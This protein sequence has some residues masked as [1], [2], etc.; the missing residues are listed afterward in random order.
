MKCRRDVLLRTGSMLSQHGSAPEIF[1]AEKFLQKKILM[2]GSTPLYNRLYLP[3]LQGLLRVSS[4]SPVRAIMEVGFSPDHPGQ[5][6]QVNVFHVEQQ[7]DVLKV[8]AK[9]IVGG[10]GYYQ[11]PAVSQMCFAAMRTEVRD[12][13]GQ[14]G[15]GVAGAG[16]MRRI[17][18]YP[19]GPMG[20][21]SSIFSIGFI[22]AMDVIRSIN[23]PV[24]PKRESVDWTL[25]EK[26]GGAGWPL[27]PSDA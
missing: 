6:E 7:A 1:A 11:R 21:A 17:S 4:M 22:S 9:G 10:Y 16:A 27:S 2:E 5:K 8:D 23:W 13:V 18:R 24:S 3:A 26:T 19:F 15:Q 14:F 12:S 20:S 25:P